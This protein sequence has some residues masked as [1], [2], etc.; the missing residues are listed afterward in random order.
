MVMAG[1]VVVR[2]TTCARP[3]P[4][5]GR[6]GSAEPQHLPGGGGPVVKASF[7]QLWWPPFDQAV[8]ADRLPVWTGEDYVDADTGEVLPTWDQALDRLDADPDASRRT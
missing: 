4:T 7:V 8:Y 6:S 1:M 2:R 3:T 5:S